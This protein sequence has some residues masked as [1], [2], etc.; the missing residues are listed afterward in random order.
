MDYWEHALAGI[1]VTHGLPLD[2]ERRQVPDHPRGKFRNT[3]SRPCSEALRD[4]ASRVDVSPF[5]LLQTAFAVLLSRW[6]G[7]TDIV[8]GTP[9]PDRLK[10]LVLRSKVDSVETFRAQLARNHQHVRSAFEHA[11]VPFDELAARL[12]PARGQGCH[13]LFQVSF[14]YAPDAA[15][16][17]ARARDNHDATALDLKLRIG[18]SDRELSI[19]W[20]FDAN[21][22]EA[23]S[24]AALA[25]SFVVLLENL[26]SA[27]DLPIAKVPL[28]DAREREALLRQAPQAAYPRDAGI[29]ALVEEQSRLHAQDVA[30][31][32]GSRSVSYAELDRLANRIAH[33]L[34]KS[35]AQPG[36]RIGTCLTRGVEL[37][38]TLLAILK[39]GAAYVP[40]DTEAPDARLS[41]MVAETG[42]R[43]LVCESRTAAARAGLRGPAHL[44]LDEPAAA[45]SP[46]T[47]LP[48][49][50]GGDRLAYVMYTSGSTGLPKGV[51]VTHRGVVRLVKNTDYARLDADTVMAQLANVAFDAATFEIWGALCNGGRLV[52]L[53]REQILDPRAFAEAAVTYRLSTAFL[54]SSLFSRFAGE[55]P[56]CFAGFR[57][58]LVGGEQVSLDAVRR[59]L[60]AGPPERLCNGYGPTENTTFSTSCELTE[61]HVRLGVMPIGHAIAHSQCH[62]VNDALELQPRGAVGELVVAG[63]GLALGYWGQPELTSLRF[64]NSPDD[65]HMPTRLY[66]TGDRVRRLP[67]G[68]L[69]FLG[70]LDTQVKL[71]GF[72]IELG[73]IEET[74]RRHPEIRDAAVVVS[75][76]DDPASRH[77]VAYCVADAG[78]AIDV[79]QLRDWLARALPKYMLPAACM[80][81]PALPLTLNGKLDRRALP[82]P[83]DAA[84]GR[85][86]YKAPHPGLETRLARRWR[87]LLKCARIGRH[88]DFIALGGNSLLLARLV[89]ELRIEFDVEPGFRAVYEARTLAGLAALIGK[90]GNRNTDALP[91]LVPGGPDAERPL[92]FAQ[93]S[94]RF[95]DRLNEGDA[96]Y[97]LSYTYR[98]RGALDAERLRRALQ[99]VVMRHESL[100]TVFRD[101]AGQA[102]QHTLA[103]VNFP[104]VEEMLQA[105]DSQDVAAALQAMTRAEALAPFDLCNDLMLRARLIRV[106]AG[107]WLLMLTVH[108]IAADGWSFALLQ[109]EL[110]GFYAAGTNGN[111]DPFEPLP[112]QY[113]DYARWQRE[114]LDDARRERALAYWRGQL[115]EL[116]VVQQLPRDNAI[117]QTARRAGLLRSRITADVVER[118]RTF[119][120]RHDATFFMTLQTAFAVLLA[121]WSGETDI[122]MGTPVANRD[123]PRLARLI[124]YFVNSVVLRSKLG[125]NPAFAELLVR[126]RGTVLDAFEHQLLPFE[127]LVEALNPERDP[128]S[129]PLFQ[130]MFVLQNNDVRDLSFPDVGVEPMPRQAAL[131]RFD[132]TLNAIPVA[133]GL[134]LEWE[135]RADRFA[136]ETIEGLA[137][138]FGVLLDGVLAEPA[139]PVLDLP[140][141]TD[142]MRQRL[143]AWSELPVDDVPDCGVH[144]LFER[145]AADQLEATAV[146][147]R[148]ESLSFGELDERAERLADFLHAEGVRPGER[149]GLCLP[150]TPDFLVSVLA[151]WKAGAA[152]VP[153][154]PELPA[155]RH[156]YIVDDAGIQR[157]LTLSRFE[158]RFADG[159]R[160][161]F[162]VDRPDFRQSVAASPKRPGGG[163]FDPSSLAYTIYTSG[164]TGEPKG[165]L[166]EHRAVSRLLGATQPLGYDGSTIMLQSVNP[167]F[168]ASVLETWAPL[169]CGGQLVLYPGQSPEPSALCDLIAEYGINTLTLPS[170]LL[171]AWVEQLDAATGL[172]CIVVG[173]EALSPDTVARLYALD[174]EV[175][176][177]NH[178]GPT[179]NGIL[180]SYYRVP[181]DFRP[182]VPIGLPVP[183]TQ[184]FVL[185]EACQIQPA[186]AVGEL[187]VA[188]QGLARGYL[189]RPELTAEKFLQPQTAAA[190]RWYRTGD[191]V[192]WQVP[193]DGSRAVL[194][195]VGRGDQQVKIRGFRI[196]LGEIEAQL[197][198]CPGVQDA[199]VVVH[200]STSGDRQLLAY[201]IAGEDA[202]ET[203]RTRLRETLPAYMVPAGFMRV[204][205]WPLTQ[206]GKV[207]LKAL[208]APDR[209]AYTLE[210]FAAAETEMEKA[211]LAIWCS[212]L[213]FERISIDDSFFQLGGHSLLATR[214]QNRIRADLEIDV[215][216]RT[217][218]EAQTIRA[219]A[220]RLEAL[221]GDRPAAES[222]PRPEATGDGTHKDAPLSYSQQRLWF[223]HRLDS[224]ATQYH[225]PYRVRLQGPLDVE[226]LRSALDAVV[227]R[228]DILRT[229][230][231]EVDGEPRQACRPFT[232]FELPLH[233]L[234]GLPADRIEAKVERL[235]HEEALKPFDL[236]RGPAFRGCL[237]RSSEHEHWLALTVHHIIADGW[238]MGILERELG[239]LYDAHRMVEPAPLPPLPLQYSDYARWQRRWLNEAVLEPHLR[240]WQAQLRDVPTLHDLPLDHARPRLQSDRGAVHHHVL[241]AELVERLEILARRHGATLFM[242]LHGAFALLLSRLSGQTDIVIGTPVANR[243]DESLAPLIGL[244]INTLVLRSDLSGVP[245]F[246][247]LLEQ[248][249]RVALDAYEHQDVPFELLVE[250]INPDRDPACSPLFQ[251]LFIL[252]NNEASTLHLS[253][254]ESTQLPFTGRSSKFDLTL[255]I[256][257]GTNHLLAEWEYNADLFEADT[258][259]RMSTAYAALLAAVLEAPERPLAGLPIVDANAHPRRTG[260][261]QQ[262]RTHGNVEPA[263]PG[264]ACNNE[265]A[266]PED[267]LQRELCA[268]WQEL[269]KQPEIGT[270]DNFFALGGYSLLLL[271]LSN[272]LRE[273][274][275]FELDLKS[276]FAEPTIRALAQ[277]IR[278][279]QQVELSEKRFQECSPSEIVEF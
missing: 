107:E 137:D 89:S 117:G 133:D 213:K 10:A 16:D 83:D 115:D 94:L 4:L 136:A 71:R 230:F 102:C 129:T 232:V 62:V 275:G 153:L 88:D 146:R 52:V 262:R 49:V 240:Y 58:L 123:D 180:T 76:N 210:A 73:E 68:E 125:D 130:I 217:L 192:R 220:A 168:D 254:L 273:V 165:V 113:A 186:G 106:K 122:V 109:E 257:P 169:C 124:G 276:F 183:G 56:D 47:G 178:Y 157:V 21:L 72:R 17:P 177:I 48:A 41:H 40:L 176:V 8:M 105:D 195:F 222:L 119:G 36:D 31:V 149:I 166:V 54:T 167:A 118:L 110:S 170:A 200:R 155:T 15:R 221:Q 191:L 229:S 95:I 61:A 224:R 69:Q 139:C 128:D 237:I 143:L 19:D 278:H 162:C 208:P 53:D 93:Q 173:G 246:V 263:V 174:D 238:A 189:D 248:S 256:Q 164:S 182:P 28:L 99:A 251:I 271:R 134:E 67:S 46:E 160:E 226:A 190:S 82:A 158:S 258:I 24:I 201:V 79:E 32:H 239:L 100:R 92:S 141:L 175:V 181:R 259:E 242:A 171:D 152:Y 74:L 234:A 267:D 12:A 244:F 63:D 37:V 6:S 138:S 204:D 233:D 235:L 194:H 114:L 7:E 80:Q 172:Q 90:P 33:A 84:Y 44:Y 131:A 185:N 120:L 5:V 243:R 78:H 272:R 43:V 23:P 39:T 231:A 199:R 121:R 65:W 87:R 202:R 198:A 266:P 264:D 42:M 142:A 20:D 111:E 156:A 60:A 27:M 145:R 34:L 22:F 265:P 64:V 148:D 101:H 255:N 223:I 75:E 29:A 96:G 2:R 211:L 212:L 108:H 225:I 279:R 98:L 236:E 70:R 35:G 66:R 184:L 188:G 97:N 57:D 209:D 277:A 132:L 59:V 150:R 38:A 151:V 85:A 206:N 261:T 1:P 269:L 215:P 45:E 103:N 218:F 104:L 86:A 77:L 135:Y 179:E 154:D 13:P 247:A 50:P 203:W 81:V 161:V 187:F 163:A 147:H 9:L 51:A 127:L 274:F 3:L 26:E 270:T 205:A 214:L 55:C 197:C 260:D 30:I 216:L 241:P 245:T 193:A 249:K 116:P 14:E 227:R 196:E 18:G 253:G 252:Q 207:D 11:D 91:D 250:R 140:V 126:N 159:T 228:H 268:I 144:E 219:L 25:G 112:V